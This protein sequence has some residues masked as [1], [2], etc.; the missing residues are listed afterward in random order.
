M[1]GGDHRA[2][3]GI[4][5]RTELVRLVGDFARILIES[6]CRYLGCRRTREVVLR[7]IVGKDRRGGARRAGEAVNELVSW[8]GRKGP[9]TR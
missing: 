8:K 6:L 1:L 7:S 5:R 4:D 9:A 2:E 3:E